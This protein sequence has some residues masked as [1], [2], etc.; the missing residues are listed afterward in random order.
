MALS[1]NDKLGQMMVFGFAASKPDEVSEGIKEMI[2]THRVGNIILF[3]RNLGS[4]GEIRSLTGKLQKIARDAGH[5][6]PL[7]ISVDQENGAVRR[8][9]EGTTV[10]PGAMTTGATGEPQLAYECGYATASELKALGIN[11]NLAPVADVNNNKHNPV[12]GVRSFSEDPEQ[13]AAFAAASMNGMQKANIMTAVKHFPGHGDTEVDSHLSLPV[14]HHDMERLNLVEL[15]PFRRCIEAGA[16][17]IMSSHI[18]FP[19]LENEKNLPVT[20]SHE[21][22]TNL[23]RVKMGFE[24]LITTDC[25]EMDAI[26]ESVGTAEGAVKAIHA[27]VDFVM[28]SM[29]TDMQRQ[30]L[31]AVK[32]DIDK[33]FISESRIEESYQRIVSAKDRYLTWRDTNLSDDTEYVPPIIDSFKHRAL[34]DDVFKKGVSIIKHDPNHFPLEKKS[35]KRILVLYPKNNYLSRVEDE[36]YASDSLG[37]T[38]AKLDSSVVHHCISEFVNEEEDLIEYAKSFDIWIIGTLSLNQ[39]NEQKQMLEKLMG[40]KT[41]E[42]VV[43]VAMKNPYDLSWFKDA[44]IKIATYEFTTPAIEI[45]ASAL[46]G[47]IIVTGVPPVTLM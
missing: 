32:R 9:G 4:P 29:R 1:I 44:D 25:L 41:N 8:L 24:G 33:G 14:I 11:W 7:F 5:E 27:G 10:F 42:T 35:Q 23:L 45:A 12:I 20:L 3:G 28:I 26:S 18:Y 34:A 2:E 47:D 36:R 13:A 30:A 17:V 21:V 22:L 40:A 19:A 46:Y 16:D 43:A 39:D 15:V 38:L 6:R 31:E 37:K